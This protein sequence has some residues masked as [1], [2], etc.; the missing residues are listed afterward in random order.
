MEAHL[1]IRYQPRSGAYTVEA[2]NGADR[3][4]LAEVFDVIEARQIANGVRAWT[5]R[6]I[7]DWTGQ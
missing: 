4:Q 2:V 7:Y 1:A 5:Q 6:P 3:V